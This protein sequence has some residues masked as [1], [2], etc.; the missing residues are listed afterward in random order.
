VLIEKIIITYITK[1]TIKYIQRTIIF[2]IVHVMNKIFHFHLYTISLIV[3]S[4]FKS[5]V[6]VLFSYSLNEKKKK[7]LKLLYYKQFK[8]NILLMS[9]Y[10]KLSNYFVIPLSQL[11][12]R[13]AHI[14][15]QILQ[16]SQFLRQCV[17]HYRVLL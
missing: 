4:T 8:Y 12:Y 9:I 15:P 7:C 5:L 11:V 14:S 16:D 13:V 10:K 2:I 1:T 3:L 17:L 6:T